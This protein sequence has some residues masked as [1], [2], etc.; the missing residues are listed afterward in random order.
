MSRLP[1]AEVRLFVWLLAA[2]EPAPDVEGGW[3]VTATYDELLAALGGS[4]RDLGPRLRLLA[5][6]G[7]VA[8]EEGRALGPGRGRSK[9]RYWLTHHPD[10]S[11]PGRGP[12][13][14]YHLGTS[15]NGTGDNNGDDGE[16][17]MPHRHIALVQEPTHGS[18]EP[19]DGTEAS[20]S[21]DGVPSVVE[22]RALSNNQQQTAS[23]SPVGPVPS[24]D[25]AVPD[26]LRRQF[27]RV[28]WAAPLPGIPPDRH[29][30]VFAVIDHLV[31]NPHGSTRKPAGLLSWLLEDPERLDSFVRS[32]RIA[33]EA[34]AASAVL[35]SVEEMPYSEWVQRSMDEPR[36]AAAVEAEASRVASVTGVKMSMRLIRQV[37]AGFPS[38]G[39]SAEVEAR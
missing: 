32:E 33:L 18:A 28:G 23:T 39:P 13:S 12:G 30:L 7:L 15:V 3:A 19:L 2:A 8:V 11:Y 37:A 26:W 31:R 1:A 22:S 21:A 6:L 4:K 20:S 16:T 25:Q 34:A 9:N 17:K 35:P 36:W 27:K 14:R 24:A 5:A 38:P 10:L 29:A